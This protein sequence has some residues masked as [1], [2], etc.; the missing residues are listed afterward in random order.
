MRL[1]YQDGIDRYL[2]GRMPDDE[3]KSFEKKCDG[4]PELKEQL[5]YTQKVKIVVSERN[6][7]LA[8]FQVWNDEYDAYNNVERHNKRTWIY[9]LSGIAAIAVV[10][11]FLFVLS[12]VSTQQ[13]P[14]VL[15]SMDTNKKVPVAD[16]VVVSIKKGIEDQEQLFAKNDADKTENKLGSGQIDDEQAFCFG[17]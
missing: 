10:G 2:L 14:S 9:G 12:D 1:E 4:N 11:Y 16:S 5:E 3:R 7:L 13:S 6:E 17:S 8:K 15:I